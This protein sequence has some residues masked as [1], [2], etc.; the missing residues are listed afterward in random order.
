MLRSTVTTH[1][2]KMIGLD[3][4]IGFLSP[5]YDADVVVWQSH[6]LSVGAAPAQ[7]YIDGIPQVDSPVLRPRSKADQSAPPAGN[8]TAEIAYDIATKGHPDYSPKAVYSSLVF[9][10]VKSI[11]LR[12][13]GALKDLHPSL[14]ASIDVFS[15]AVENG[16]ITCIGDCVFSS[17]TTVINL[18]GG[19]IAPGLIAAGSP[20]GL[21][22]IDL[23][24][25][26]EP[27]APVDPINS[28]PPSLTRFSLDKAADGISFGTKGMWRTIRSG[29]T[30]SIT[31]PATDATFAGVSTFF[32]VSAKHP[33]DAGILVDSLGLHIRIFHPPDV[34]GT[35]VSTQLGT[36]R[37]LLMAEDGPA[38]GTP[39][40][41]AFQSAAGGQ[42][43]LIIRV[44][45]ADIMARLILIKR[46]VEE[47]KR[48][49]MRVVFEG[50]SEAHLLAAEIAKADI[51]VIVAP[52]RPFPTVVKNQ[53]AS[54]VY[55]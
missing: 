40:S 25:H 34:G 12:R 22:E 37:A 5:G 6:P 42:M 18:E 39:L 21:Q 14:S 36:I 27:P 46:Q 41:A 15:V 11:V 24:I 3:H 4:R 19:S 49:K 47:A 55:P 51:G 10:N 44:T 29:V 28:N 33:L 2:A 26:N 30:H 48:S 53:D 43:V 35:T 20:L 38:I 23:Q 13:E 8:F 31:S 50:A 17:D 52:P 32:R 9:T 1:P 16:E 7:V 54:Q 45:H